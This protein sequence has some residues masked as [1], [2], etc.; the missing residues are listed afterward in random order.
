MSD[1]LGARLKPGNGMVLQ[2]HGYR[3]GPCFDSLLRFGMVEMEIFARTLLGRCGED[4]GRKCAGNLVS[5]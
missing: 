4:G 2:D 5:R 1:L 3:A